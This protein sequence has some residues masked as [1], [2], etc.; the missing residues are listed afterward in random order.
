M[1]R[2]RPATNSARARLRL[3]TSSASWPVN[4]VLTGTSVAPA[5]SAPSAA[6]TQCCVFGDQMA[7]RSP[8]PTPAAIS[9]RLTLVLCS[10]TSC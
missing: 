4:R 6:S 1:P 9:A 5:P 7:T 10:C 8:G 2:K 3:I